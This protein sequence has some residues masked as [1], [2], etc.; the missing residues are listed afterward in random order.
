MSLTVDFGMITPLIVGPMRYFFGH[1]TGDSTNLVWAPDEKDRT[2][3]IGEAFDFNK[4]PLQEKPRIIVARGPIGL[5]KTG[6]SDNLAGAD[7]FNATGGRKKFD[8]F[9]IYNGS[10]SFLIEARNKGTCEL[11]AA[12]ATKFLVWSRPLLCDSQAFKE[13]GLPLSVSDCV[14]QPD[15]DPAITKFQI[16][17]SFPWVK[18][19][20]F[21][22]RNDGV[23][24][25]R[26]LLYTQTSV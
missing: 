1:Y 12:L 7:P 3:D 23:T 13:I 24:L 20:N 6:I 15:E 9:L 5:Q 8:H 22:L 17:V 18:E 2:V 14:M 26:I 25:K 21:T 11:L 16:Q 19:E 4:V 10:A